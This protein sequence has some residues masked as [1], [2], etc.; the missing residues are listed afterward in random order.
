MMFLRKQSEANI[1][2]SNDMSNKPFRQSILI[3]QL[4]TNQA[5][6]QTRLLEE[7]CFIKLVNL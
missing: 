5:M 7:A 2:L 4:L 3:I 6:M 1:D